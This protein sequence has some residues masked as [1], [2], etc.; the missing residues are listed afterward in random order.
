MMADRQFVVVE[1]GMI[2]IWEFEPV[3]AY[4]VEKRPDG[5]LV[6]TPLTGTSDVQAARTAVAAAALEDVDEY[7]P[8][9]TIRTVYADEWRDRGLR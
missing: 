2:D 4:E 3:D 6:L 8:G 1:N 9:V 7:S 5:T